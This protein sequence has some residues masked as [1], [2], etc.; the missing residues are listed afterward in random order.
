M[1]FFYILA[2]DSLIISHVTQFEGP[3]T[4]YFQL[5]QQHSAKVNVLKKFFNFHLQANCISCNNC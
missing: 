2:G 3:V 5:K 4:D 1:S